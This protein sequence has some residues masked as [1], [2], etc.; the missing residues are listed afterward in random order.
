MRKRGRRFLRKRKEGE[1]KKERDEEKLSSQAGRLSCLVKELGLNF[2]L[3]RRRL[4]GA[5]TATM[6]S[7][8]WMLQVV[9]RVTLNIM[10][11]GSHLGPTKKEISCCE[12]ILLA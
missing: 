1:K 3:D 11:Q 12:L 10:G 8:R 2:S 9:M 5:R 4:K 7:T 6:L